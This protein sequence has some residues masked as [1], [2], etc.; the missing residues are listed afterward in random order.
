MPKVID[1]IAKRYEIVGFGP[2]LLMCAPWRLRR[3]GRAIW[4][5]VYRSR[6]IGTFRST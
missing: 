5:N 1:G 3:S 2:A 6:T 4:K